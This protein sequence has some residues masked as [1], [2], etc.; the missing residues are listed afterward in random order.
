MKARKDFCLW[1]LDCMRETNL[2]VNSKAHHISMTER[3]PT[4][5]LICRETLHVGEKTGKGWRYNVEVMFSQ[6]RALRVQ[7]YQ[8][9]KHSLIQTRADDGVKKKNRKKVTEL[10]KHVNRCRCAY[11]KQYLASERKSIEVYQITKKTKCGY[12]DTI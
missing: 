5:S 7:D 12:G 10:A 11:Q 3:P 9:C 4:L 2:S 8:V 6:G 1:S